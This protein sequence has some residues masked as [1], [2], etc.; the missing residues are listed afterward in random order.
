MF[1]SSLQHS[2][3][4]CTAKDVDK[5]VVIIYSEE[6]SPLRDELKIC[7]GIPLLT[8]PYVGTQTVRASVLW[9]APLIGELQNDAWETM[10]GLHRHPVASVLAHTKCILSYSYLAAV[11]MW[12]GKQVFS[13]NKICAWGSEQKGVYSKH[14]H[15]AGCL[16][17]WASWM[18]ALS[19]VW[20]LLQIPLPHLFL[21]S[22][23]LPLLLV[24]QYSLCRIYHSPEL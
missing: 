9:A 23:D 19:S 24:L 6:F 5:M 14:A 22:R 4:I 18:E 2:W 13:W 11:E 1:P 7:R 21:P 12:S 8:K 15:S 10:L 17:S 16:V 3:D 20:P